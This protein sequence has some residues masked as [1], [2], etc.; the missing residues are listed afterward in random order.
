MPAFPSREFASQQFQPGKL[1]ASRDSSIARF[2]SNAFAEKASCFI[3]YSKAE[4]QQIE[5]SDKIQPPNLATTL[6]AAP[7]SDRDNPWR[8][9]NVDRTT[10]GSLLFY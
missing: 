5:I 8:D 2:Q 7:R 6:A 4:I 1:T 9:S 10:W 3:S